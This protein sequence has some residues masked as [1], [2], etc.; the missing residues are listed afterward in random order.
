MLWAD[1]C[2]LLKRIVFETTVKKQ[3]DIIKLDSFD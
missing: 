1:D 2:F 3:F